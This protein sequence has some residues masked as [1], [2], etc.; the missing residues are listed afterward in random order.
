MTRNEV[1]VKL[2]A[3]TN[4]IVHELIALTPESMTEI[5]FELVATD[6]GGADVGLLESHPDAKKVV[7]SD[8]IYRAASQYLPLIKQ[9]LPGWSHSLLI[10][11]QSENG[12]QVRV[13]F[14]QT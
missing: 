10:L 9:Y 4:A 7:L 2:H 1:E 6:D 3:V 5:K 14:E 12:W 13:E 11:R 8:A